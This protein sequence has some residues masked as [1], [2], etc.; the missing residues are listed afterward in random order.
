MIIWWSLSHWC[1]IRLKIRF[2]LQLDDF[3]ENLTLFRVLLRHLK[4]MIGSCVACRKYSHTLINKIVN[5]TRFMKTNFMFG[6]HVY[7]DLVR[8]NANIRYKKV[9]ALLQISFISGE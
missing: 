5:Q 4:S 9:A 8:I 7:I 3:Q 6:M 2:H 1:L